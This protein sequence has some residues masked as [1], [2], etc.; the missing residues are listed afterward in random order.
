M[1]GHVRPNDL[2]GKKKMETRL[3]LA[4]GKLA[5]YNERWR[6]L[7]NLVEGTKQP[8]KK[9]ANRELKDRNLCFQ[10]LCAVLKKH[11]F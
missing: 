3:F 5:K 4:E 7:N 1:L 2:K 8:R 11:I 6:I 10:L 9:R